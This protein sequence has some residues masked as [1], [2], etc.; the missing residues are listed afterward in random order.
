MRIGARQMLAW[1]AVVCAI[2]TCAAMVPAR[3]DITSDVDT[4][5]VMAVDISNSVDE[6]RYRLQLEGIAAALEDPGV[7]GAILNGPRGAILLSIVAWGDRPEIALPWVAIR[8]KEDAAAAAA[9]VRG[10][11]RFSGEFTCMARALQFLNDK[12]LP[13]VPAKAL[14]TVVDVS[15]DGKDNCN[16]DTSVPALRDEIVSYGTTINGLPILEGSEAATLEQWYEENVKGGFGS[17]ILPADGFEDFGRAI[18]QKFIVEI[19]G[20]IDPREAAAPTQ[21]RHPNALHGGVR[22]A[23]EPASGLTFRQR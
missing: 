10:L 14:R 17:F 13:Q 3:S 1:T 23:R 12:V 16:A 9:K 19:S 7:V 11:P 2:L 4:A 18:R 5:L 21:A 22:L 15:G 8:S 20:D 6:R